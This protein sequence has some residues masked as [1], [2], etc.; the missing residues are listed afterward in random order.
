TLYFRQEEVVKTGKHRYLE[1][2][3]SNTHV[4]NK[5]LEDRMNNIQ[6]RNTY[7]KIE[8]VNVNGIVQAITTPLP[9]VHR[10]ANRESRQTGEL[11]GQTNKWVVLALAA[12][13]TF[14]T[15]LDSSIVNIG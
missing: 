3:Q 12:T 8:A 10:T 14:M 1:L 4:L 2:W 15:T 7:G 13:A 5:M 9:A 6:R 11:T